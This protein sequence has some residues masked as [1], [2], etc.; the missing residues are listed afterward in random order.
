MLNLNNKL[1][2]MKKL[3]IALL[4]ISSITIFFSCSNND[5]STTP[6]E[7]PN[8]VNKWNIDKWIYNSVNQTLNTCEKQGYIQ[9][10][11]NGT[12]VRKAYYLNG[13]SCE[14]EDD[15]N[16][17]YTYNTTTNKITINFNDPVD[18]AQ[19]EVYNNVQLTTTTLKYS[20]DE[21]GNGTDEHNL[22]FK[23]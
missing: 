7:Q 10:N 20:W 2:L 14:L 12:F 16:G 9:F 17:T 3:K 13:T 23:K 11:S 1:N 22:E 5:D 4:I 21:D 15:D 6:T 19:V 18:G 8:L